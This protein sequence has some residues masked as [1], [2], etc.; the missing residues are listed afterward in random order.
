MAAVTHTV[1]ALTIRGVLTAALIAAA[2]MVYVM[3][4][5]AALPIV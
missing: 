1:M 5:A 4:Q 3:T 2:T